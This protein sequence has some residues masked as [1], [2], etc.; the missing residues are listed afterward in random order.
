M[1]V[2]SLREDLFGFMNQA[3]KPGRKD[4]ESASDLI[5]FKR[6][7]VLSNEEKA[8]EIFTDQL[9]ETLPIAYDP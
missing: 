4:C 7:N 2:D 6:A 9:K 1:L 3:L 5:V 8:G